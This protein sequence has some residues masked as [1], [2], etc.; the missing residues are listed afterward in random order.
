MY[1][2]MDGWMDVYV[3]MYVYVYSI[4]ILSFW[5]SSNS[6]CSAAWQFHPHPRSCGP[7]F[8]AP[9]TPFA[10]GSVSR[11]NFCRARPVCVCVWWCRSFVAAVFV[12]A[13]VAICGGGGGGSSGRRRCW[14]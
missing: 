1:V 14:C 5:P 8:H 3:C 12:V 7:S 6:G 13:A 11:S 2:C 4:Y 9:P 10:G